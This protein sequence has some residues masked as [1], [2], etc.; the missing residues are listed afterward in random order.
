ML[1]TSGL[2]PA[3]VLQRA[4]K[5]PQFS[6][7]ETCDSFCQRINL[8]IFLGVRRVVL[9][10]TR[11]LEPIRIVFEHHGGGARRRQSLDDL[12][13]RVFRTNQK[14]PDH[15]ADFHTTSQNGCTELFHKIHSTQTPLFHR[16]KGVGGWGEQ[17]RL[18]EGPSQPFCTNTRKGGRH[19]G[20][21]LGTP[22]RLEGKSRE[23]GG[24]QTRSHFKMDHSS[25]TY[26]QTHLSPF[27]HNFICCTIH[28]VASYIRNV[29][30]FVA[31][32]FT[33]L[34]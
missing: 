17:T 31:T 12:F 3:P 19:M 15:V 9:F 32:T 11:V 22:T 33:S 2:T 21:T 23:R 16:E 24:E 34:N 8:F 29:C 10:I 4:E 26:V 30:T 5:A 20:T 14:T 1:R 13:K 28:S 7:S 6:H 25:S 27:I 18:K